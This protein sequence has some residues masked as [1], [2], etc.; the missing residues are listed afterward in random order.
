MS[1]N[2]T[3]YAVH[4]LLSTFIPPPSN[5]SNYKICITFSLRGEL[6]DLVRV[7]GV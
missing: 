7:Q 3:D 5:K 2:D 4:Q 6:A 1:V